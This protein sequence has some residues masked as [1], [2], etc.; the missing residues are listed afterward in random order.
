M[1]FPKVTSALNEG[2]TVK[3]ITFVPLSFST[4]GFATIIFVLNYTA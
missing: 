2:Y 3:E 1:D 4:M